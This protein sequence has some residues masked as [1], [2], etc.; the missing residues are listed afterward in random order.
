MPTVLLRKKNRVTIPASIIRKTGLKEN[1]P[2]EIE[3]AEQE[4]GYRI[5][6]ERLKKPQISRRKRGLSLKSLY[7]D[8]S[9]ES[10]LG[11]E[12]PWGETAG[13]EAW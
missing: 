2:L 1:D 4:D 9:I 8:F 7:K 3:V 10:S 6:I 11:D 12:V 13:D 5:I